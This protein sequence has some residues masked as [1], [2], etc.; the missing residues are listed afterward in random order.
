VD[1]LAHLRGLLADVAEVVL[2]LGGGVEGLLALIALV[3]AGIGEVAEG[4]GAD[5]EAVGEP[6]IA[7][8]AVALGHLLLGGLLLVVDAQEDLLGDARVPLR[9]RPAEVVEPDVEPLVHLRV[10]LVVEVADFLRSFLLLHRLY[11]RGRT[12]LVRPADVEHVGALEFLK[13]GEDVGGEDAAND[14]AEVGHI[15]D[16]GEGGC[17][18]DVVLVLARQAGVRLE[19]DLLGGELLAVLLR[20]FNLFHLWLLLDPAPRLLGRLLRC[21]L[22]CCLLRFF[23]LAGQLFILGGKPLF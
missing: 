10:D 18:E 12:V 1:G 2:E 7:I 3:A 9:A 4:T 5:D 11:F 23:F 22:R 6:E 14:V 21:C 20:D 19:D 15:V 16:I 8:A 13:A 17:D